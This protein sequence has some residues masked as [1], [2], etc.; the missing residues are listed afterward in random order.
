MAWVAPGASVVSLRD[1]L[2]GQ[3]VDVAGVG[4]GRHRG[5]PQIHDLRREL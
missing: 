4:L 5:K 2:V 3:R 1:H